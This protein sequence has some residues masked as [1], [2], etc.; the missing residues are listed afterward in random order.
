[1]EQLTSEAASDGRGMAQRAV[2][3]QVARTGPASYKSGGIPC[4]SCRS[5]TVNF[6]WRQS[7]D[8]TEGKCDNGDCDVAWGQVG[9]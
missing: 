2:A 6:V 7:T 3:A 4:P 9:R 1:M 5:G 8:D